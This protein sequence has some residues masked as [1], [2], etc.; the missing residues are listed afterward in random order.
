MSLRP[1]DEDLTA[2]R[3]ALSVASTNL[4]D[5]LATI[6]VEAKTLGRTAGRGRP[7]DLSTFYALVNEVRRMEEAVDLATLDIAT[8]S[9]EDA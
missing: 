6:A 2:Q 5:S 7:V 1:Q 9:G 8:A 3:E 4:S